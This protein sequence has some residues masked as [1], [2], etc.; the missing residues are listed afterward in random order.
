MY[1]YMNTYTYTC[2]YTYIWVHVDNYNTHTYIYIYI[3]THGY[4]D[5]SLCDKLFIMFELLLLCGNV[6]HFVPPGDA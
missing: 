5:I 3:Y 6:E 2:I 1:I 4:M